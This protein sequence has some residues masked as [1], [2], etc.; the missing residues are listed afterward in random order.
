[1]NSGDVGATRAQRA[2]L[3]STEVSGLEG[4][5]RRQRLTI[6]GLYAAPVLLLT[7]L[8]FL[9]QSL[10]LDD[11]YITL[12]NARTLLAGGSDNVYPE[13]TALTGAT[14]AVHLVLVAAFGT[15]LPLELASKFSSLI[16]ILLY[17]AGLIELLRRYQSP[18]LVSVGI[19]TTGLLIGYMPYH[20]LNGLETGLALAGIVWAFVLIDSRWLPLL[21][22]TLPFIRPELAFL[23]APLL[24]R[25]FWIDRYQLRQLG[26]DAALVSLAAFP[27]LLLYL[28]QTG[29]PVPNTGGAKLAFFAESRLPVGMRASLLVVTV[30]QCLIGPL[31]LSLVALRHQ[32][33]GICAIIFLICWIGFTAMAFPGGLHHNYFRYLSLTIPPLLLG[34]VIVFSKPASLHK[35]VIILI[36][37]WAAATSL[38]G[39]RA[40]LDTSHITGLEKTARLIDQQ[41]PPESVILVHDAGYLAWALPGRKL[42]DVVGLKTPSSS[43]WHHLYTAGEGRRDMALDRIATEAGAT[44]FVALNDHSP[45]WHALVSQLEQQQWQLQPVKSEPGDEYVIYHLR[46]ATGKVRKPS[47]A[48]AE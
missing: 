11:A 45:F 3:T 8:L 6:S 16:G 31:W 40:Y 24:L 42:T 39:I 29:S 46:R 30:A 7:I 34:W 22:G 2:D 1:M 21:C 44:H 38:A 36:M 35:P 5:S 41:L 10:P 4:G 23:A 33:A 27:W 12:H 13:A 28:V 18:P 17:A 32:P 26:L 19:V 48:L 14:S 25:R 15:V 47:A 9:R 43:R 37:A 20:L